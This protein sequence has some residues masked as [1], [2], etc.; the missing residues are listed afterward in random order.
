MTDTAETTYATAVT[1][2][3]DEP[4]TTNMAY[5]PDNTDM[6]DITDIAD[7]TQVA[8][9]TDRAACLDALTRRTGWR[10]RTR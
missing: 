2:A 5:A 8:D 1:D 6:G 7:M 4:A 10:V 9:V 3:P